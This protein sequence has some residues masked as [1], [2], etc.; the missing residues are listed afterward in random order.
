MVTGRFLFWPVGAFARI[1]LAITRERAAEKGMA[2]FPG[3]PACLEIQAK[4]AC[5]TGF[6][7]IA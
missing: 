2:A 4:P 3:V 5:F 1:S 7:V 6:R